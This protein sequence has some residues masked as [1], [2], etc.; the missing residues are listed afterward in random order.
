MS[1]VFEKKNFIH[2]SAWKLT[3]GYDNWIQ[4]HE[5]RNHLS[6]TTEVICVMKIHEEFGI[7]V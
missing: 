5:E 2:L 7:L 6:I 4:I 3:L 1:K